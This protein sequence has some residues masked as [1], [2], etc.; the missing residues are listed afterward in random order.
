MRTG[1]RAKALL[2]DTPL[3]APL[4]PSRRGRMCDGSE[5]GDGFFG[6]GEYPL[7]VRGGRAFCGLG[8]ARCCTLGGEGYREMRSAVVSRT[9]GGRDRER[10]R[11]NVKGGG[12]RA[13]E[14]ERGQREAG[15]RTAGENSQEKQKGCPGSGGG[16]G[17]GAGVEARVRGGR[18]GAKGRLREKRVRG[19]GA[20]GERG[21]EGST[22]KRGKV[23][24]SGAGGG[25]RGGGVEASPGP[26]APSS[27]WADGALGRR[28][29][30]PRG[31]GGGRAGAARDAARSG[32][33]QAAHRGGL[34]GGARGDDNAGGLRAG[35]PA[36]GTASSGEAGRA[37]R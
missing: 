15:R 8:R 18:E 22:E 10:D 33:G 27:V 21:G 2:P 26:R 3:P 34:G 32:S 1:Q 16:R 31:G 37:L 29:P 25:A 24:T 19:A 23:A 7:I 6:G 35:L 20:R 30:G 12:R 4:W 9:E 11:V 5:R 13:G 28:E 14:R 17:G 36:G